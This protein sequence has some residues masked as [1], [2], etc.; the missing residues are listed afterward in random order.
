MGNTVMGWE[1]F[2][3]ENDAV[4]AE[5][6]KIEQVYAMWVILLCNSIFGRVLARYDPEECAMY[7]TFQIRSTPERKIE[8]VERVQGCYR[9][10]IGKAMAKILTERRKELAQTVAV[11]I[12]KWADEEVLAEDWPYY[13][14]K[15]IYKVVRAI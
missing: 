13:L 4:Q 5:L 12:P 1:T 9:G 10:C 15:S 2:S 6:E 3:S 11:A 7:V 8:C 14:E